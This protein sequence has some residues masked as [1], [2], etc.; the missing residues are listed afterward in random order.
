MLEFLDPNIMSMISYPNPAYLLVNGEGD[1]CE[2]LHWICKLVFQNGLCT[3]HNGLDAGDFHSW[4]YLGKHE[5]T[6]IEHDGLD[7]CTI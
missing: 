7:S 5:A 4:I 1:A 2:F 6:D 3:L